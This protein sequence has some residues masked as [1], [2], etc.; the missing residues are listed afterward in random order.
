MPKR[1][2]E[3]QKLV[4]LIKK[5]AALGATVT[6]SKL[7][8][9]NITGAER[10]VDICIE[11]VVAG[12]NVTISIECRDR[13]R[14][15]NVQWVEEMKAKHE[16]LPTNALVLVSSSGF[17]K[18]AARVARSYGMETA[19]LD[20]VDATAAEGLFGSTG[21]LWSKVFTL[22]RTKVVIG[23]A[24]SHGLAAETVA[25]SPDNL[26][27]DHSGHI[28]GPVKDLVEMLLHAECAVQ[29]FG[30]LGDR[31]HKGFE[32]RWEPAADKDGSRFCLQKLNPCILRAI[33][34]V[35]ITGSCN[36]D[37]SEFPLQHGKLGS[38]R[39]AWGT[40]TFLGKKALLV[41]SEDQGA[42]KKLTISTENDQ[43]KSPI[44]RSSRGRSRGAR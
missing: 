36:F 43:V 30:K 4:L 28:I 40:G 25:V 22:N 13:G 16:R 11:S 1:S 42:G 37:I 14:K 21:S 7:L 18:E 9:D 44:K 31:S 19:T 24:S 34:F 15:A 39:V 27:Y 29:E 17:T 23:V 26:V 38:I 3:F 8:R 2:N 32:I 41:A 12:H 5:H 10:E 35:R 33:E 20:T 6:E